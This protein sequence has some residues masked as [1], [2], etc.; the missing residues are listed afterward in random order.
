MCP[1]HFVI[2]TWREDQEDLGKSSETYTIASNS[3]QPTNLKDNPAHLSVNNTQQQML[4]MSA[5]LKYSTVD[6][7]NQRTVLHNNPAYFSGKR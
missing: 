6:E 7:D 4:M 5:D 1:Y 3:Q 2:C